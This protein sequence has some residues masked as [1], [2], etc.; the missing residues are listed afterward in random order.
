MQF[1]DYNFK[2]VFMCQNKRLWILYTQMRILYSSNNERVLIN[3]G[4]FSEVLRFQKPIQ[5]SDYNLL[6]KNT[7]N[8]AMYTNQCVLY[9]I[10]N[11]NQTLLGILEISISVNDYFSFDEEYYGVILAKL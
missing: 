8:I 4:S 6:C 9:S 10:F 5:K 1:I 2:H 7:N 11:Q 3:K